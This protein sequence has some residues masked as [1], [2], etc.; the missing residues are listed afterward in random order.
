[1]ATPPRIKVLCVELFESPYRLRLPFRFG[2]ITVTEGRQ[3][4]TRVRVRHESGRE[5]FGFAAEALGAKWFD[6]NPALSDAQNHDQLR[7][8]LELTRDA[9]L[10]APALSA[11]GLHAQHY[12]SILA[13]GASQGLDGL[14][15]S[16]GPALLDRAILDALLRVEGVSFWRGMQGNLPGIVADTLA[17]DLQGF[18]ID[19]FLRNLQPA[20]SIHVRHTVGLL[21]PL[22]ASDQPPGTRVNDGLPETLEEVVQVYGN[23]YFKLK[24]CGQRDADL[25]RLQRI[26]SVLDHSPAPYWVTLDGN[27]QYDDAQAIAAMWQAMLATPGL[28]R[29]CASTL[30][31]E[32]PI[33]RARALSQ[34]VA[35]LAHF[36]P[37][38]IDES[39][40]DLDAFIRAK[41]LG[42]TGVSSKNCKG[43]YKSVLNLARC[44]VWNGAA[45]GPYFM[46]AEDLTTQAGVS[47]QQDLALVSLLGLAHVE[48]NAHHFIDGFNGRPEAEAQA[49]LQAH[50]DL[51]HL[52]DGRAHLHIQDGILQ[53]GSLDCAGFGSGVSPVLDA[54][55]LMAP[56]V[57]PPMAKEPA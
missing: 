54:T 7:R 53:L 38:I 50:P 48:R 56:A 45:D 27:E 26:A 32:Q 21:D 28:Q 6:K 30:M 17:S 33:R 23:R 46:S 2:V 16:F 52:H 25:D 55:A 39:D 47:V 44:S 12:R 34:P 22:V 40:G 29:L 36:K 51:Y 10:A 14:V 18:A 8:T 37:V 42:Y 13:A 20:D 43:F 4:I 5:A 24:V 9:Y 3:V 41:A 11:F 49:Y 31:V 19:G 15:S 1:M 57:W 35:P